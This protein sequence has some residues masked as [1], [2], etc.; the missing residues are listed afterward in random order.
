MAAKV[1]LAR[2]DDEV[3]DDE[4]DEREKGKGGAGDAEP[5][6]ALPA[7]FSAQSLIFISRSLMRLLPLA[8]AAGVSAA[9]TLPPNTL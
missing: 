6:R 9:P 4:A 2:G 8:P 7:N 3:G 5:I 1:E